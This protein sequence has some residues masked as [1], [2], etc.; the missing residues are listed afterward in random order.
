MISSTSGL[1]MHDM[2]Y[3]IMADRSCSGKGLGGSSAV[4]F[5]AYNKPTKKEI[6]G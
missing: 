6:D 4:N 5:M 2:E 1:G 3:S